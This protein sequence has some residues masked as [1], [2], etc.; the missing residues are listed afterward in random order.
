MESFAALLTGVLL[1]IFGWHVAVGARGHARKTGGTLLGTISQR[2][3]TILQVFW[4]IV[5]SLWLLVVALGF[6]LGTITN[7]AGSLVMLYSG[8]IPFWG[9]IIAHLR[10][11]DAELRQ[12][13]LVLPRRRHPFAPW[14]EVFYLMWSHRGRSLLVR[15]VAGDVVLKTDPAQV[16]TITAVLLPRVRVRDET[17][18]MVNLDRDLL[19]IDPS[20]DHPASRYQFRLGTLLLFMMVASSAFAW[21]GIHVRMG[22]QQDAVLA[23]YEEFGPS[24]NRFG[25]S[26]FRLDFSKCTTSPGDA[27]LV[28]LRDLPKLRFLDLTNAPITDTGLV[29][30]ESLKQLDTITLTGTQVTEEGVRKLQDALPDATIHH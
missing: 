19:K 2:R 8:Y 5:G 15:S 6:A 13:G 14:N 26:V 23:K 17:G 28:Y 29:H 3:L 9:V 24:V 16:N 1:A 7:V 21:L 4:W 30:L 25:N 11:R 12:R 27:D 20:P 18:K 10:S 22:R